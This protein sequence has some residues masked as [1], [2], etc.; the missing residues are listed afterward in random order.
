[1]RVMNSLIPLGCGVVVVGMFLLSAGFA[2][3]IAAL[4]TPGIVAALLGFGIIVG[5]PVLEFLYWVSKRLRF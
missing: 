4:Q 1:M 3:P 5:A 2:V